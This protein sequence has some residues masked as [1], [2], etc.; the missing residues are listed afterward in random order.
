[1]TCVTLSQFDALA[2]DV[3][4]ELYEGFVSKLKAVN[5]DLDFVF[6]YSC[7]VTNDFYDLSLIHI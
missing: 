6:G 7:L 2:G 3:Y 4:P 5:L 1:M